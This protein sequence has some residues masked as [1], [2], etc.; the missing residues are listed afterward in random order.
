MTLH[1]ILTAVLTFATAQSEFRYRVTTPDGAA[2]PGALA[3]LQCKPSQSLS[4]VSDADGRFSFTDVRCKDP[5]LTVKLE[6]FASVEL[7]VVPDPAYTL[8]LTL[9]PDSPGKPAVVCICDPLSE[10]TPPSMRLLRLTD[11][12]GNAVRGASVSLSGFESGFQITEAD[13]LVC[14]SATVNRHTYLRVTHRL[15][16]PLFIES[17]CAPP[18]AVM[19]LR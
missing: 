17:C 1:L 19:H 5:T 9:S 8:G 4:R 10:D 12:A 18:A 14:F 3:T 11:E 7:P 16:E 6:G 13:G 15:F 2:L